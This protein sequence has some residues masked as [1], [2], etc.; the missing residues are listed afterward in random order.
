MASCGVRW[1]ASDKS[2]GTRKIGL[3]L[4]RQGI[5]EAGKDNPESRAI[6]FMEHCRNAIA[7]IPVLPRDAKNSEDV[8]TK[9]ED[10]M[11]DAIRYRVLAQ[12]RGTA[13]A[14]YVSGGL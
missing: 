1:E 3:E 11:Y 12:Q 9:S 5:R 2:S 7:Q 4:M 10:H 14:L 6:Y 8:C 13:G